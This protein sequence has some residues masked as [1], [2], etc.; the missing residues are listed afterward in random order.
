MP[1][2]RPGDET[3]KYINKIIMHLCLW[4]GIGLAF[5][6]AYTYLINLIPFIQDIVMALGSVPTVVTGS[7]IVIMV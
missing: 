3:A 6:G 7:G 1:G 4:G 5:V 2:I